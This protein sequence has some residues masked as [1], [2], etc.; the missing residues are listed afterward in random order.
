MNKKKSAITIFKFKKLNRRDMKNIEKSNLPICESYTY[1]GQVV[2]SNLKLSDMMKKTN[3][4]I[5]WIMYKLAGIRMRMN[6]KLNI[7]L[8]K[9][10]C[11]PT[12]RLSLLNLNITNSTDR[13]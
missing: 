13:K 11:Q 5:M 8:W 2:Q 6:L 12:I 7:N 9:V 3:K 1:L 10:F 4:K